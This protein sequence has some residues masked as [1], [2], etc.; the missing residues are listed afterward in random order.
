MKKILALILALTM[1]LA[2]AACGETGTDAP[3][4]SPSAS[5]PNS[6]SGGEEQ[7]GGSDAAGGRTLTVGILNGNSAGSDGF[8]PV[9]TANSVGVNLVF[10]TL[11]DIDP[12]TSEAVGI[13][14]ESWS[15]DDDT[16]LRVKLYDNAAFSNGDPVTAEDVYWSWYRNI[17]ENSS[18]AGNLAFIDWDNWEFVSDK[19]FVISYNE[20]F[21]PAVNYMTMRCFSVMSKAAMENATSDD[22]WSNPVG[23]G[24]YIVKEN[25]SGSYSSYTRRADYWNPDTMPQAEEITIR[26]YS[27]ASTMYID[28]E[29]GNLDLAWEL[30]VTDAD[31]AAAGLENARLE[32]ISMNNVIGIAF[33]EYTEALNDIRVREALACAMDVEALAEMGYGSLATVSST[34]IPSGVQNVVNTG[35]QEY[36]PDRAKQLLEEA[37]VSGLTLSLVIVGSPANERIAT[38]LAAYYQ[39][40]GVTLNVESCDLATAISHFMNSETDIV[41]NSGSVVSMDTYEALMMTLATSTNATIRITDE[42]YNEDLLAGRSASDDAARA[43]SYTEAQQWLHDNYRQVAICEPTVAYVYRT[44]KIASINSMPDEAMTLRYVEFV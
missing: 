33:P 5:S 18:D 23:S 43:Q 10:E 41:L 26:N 8:D 34:I 3:D 4:S 31:R 37:N 13:L 16:H 25:I 1:L 30:D 40:V 22:Y 12:A 15:Y 35:I 28:F 6:P 19:E 9:S 21:G 39:A 7:P 29:T 44:D 27:D 38:A 2:L 20:P 42:S 14:A 32:T 24:P 11:M 36:N 17:S